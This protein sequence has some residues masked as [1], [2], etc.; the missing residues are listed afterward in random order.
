LTGKVLLVLSDRH[1]TVLALDSHVVRQV[2]RRLGDDAKSAVS[3]DDSIE[4]IRILSRARLDQ[5]A[6][7]EDHL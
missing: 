6:V 7:R 5:G 4:D 1:R 3:T 2:K